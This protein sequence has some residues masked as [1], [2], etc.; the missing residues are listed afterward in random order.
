MKKIFQYAE[1][2]LE[3][4][5]DVDWEFVKKGRWGEIPEDD[6][7]QDVEMKSEEPIQHVE[8]Y[9]RRWRCE[10]LSRA[11]FATS[12][13]RLNTIEKHINITVNLEILTISTNDTTRQIQRIERLFKRLSQQQT[14]LGELGSLDKITPISTKSPHNNI[15]PILCSGSDAYHTDELLSVTPRLNS[16]VT[17]VIMNRSLPS[18]YLPP[19]IC[20]GRV[21]PVSTNHLGH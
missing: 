13:N 4:E 5:S 9:Q 18:I 15:S 3:A 14:L 21:V 19:F 12:G 20:P 8:K 2:S 11:V 1:E 17:L 6:T 16:S 7:D 10:R